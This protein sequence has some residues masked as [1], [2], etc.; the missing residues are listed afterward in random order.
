MSV[1]DFIFFYFFEFKKKIVT[2][3]AVVVPCGSDRV[4]W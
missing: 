4:M 2:C 1:L 3:Q